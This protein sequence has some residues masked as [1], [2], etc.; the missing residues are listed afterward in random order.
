MEN[1]QVIILG[2]ICLLD[3]SWTA[4][5]NY[6]GCGW[7]WMDSSGKNQL[8]GIRNLTRRESTLHLKVEALRWAMENMLQ[9]STCQSFGTDCKELIAMVKEPHAWPSFATELERIKTLQICF[10]DFN[11]THC[12]D[13]KYA[14]VKWEELGFG[15]YRT[16]NMYV[17]KCKHGESFQEGI[18]LFLTLIFRSA[19]ALQFL[20]MA[21]TEDGRIMLFRPDQNALRLQSGAH[22]LCMPYPSV[23]QFVSAVKQVVLANK[24][25]VCIKLESKR[26]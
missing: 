13:E 10:P 20:I 21:R 11:I 15:F 17:A 12:A 9:H 3:G 1:P 7:V 4:S 22:R 14:N 25:W 16:D 19:L 18:V 2:N 5:A 24:K 8:M 23:D 6:S 26:F